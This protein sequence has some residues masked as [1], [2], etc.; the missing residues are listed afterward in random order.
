VS[1]V[2]EAAQQEYA[3]FYA[4]NSKPRVLPWANKELDQFI[5]PDQAA[6]TAVYGAHILGMHVVSS[7]HANGPMFI[8]CTTCNQRIMLP[9]E[10]DKSVA[11]LIHNCKEAWH[12]D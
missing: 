11:G 4:D 5:T 10:T 3:Q 1:G 7:L 12:F 6:F 2:S 8:N 9:K